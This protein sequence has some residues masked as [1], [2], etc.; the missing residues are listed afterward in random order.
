MEA[1]LGPL[2]WKES[3]SKDRTITKFLGGADPTDRGD[4]PRQHDWLVDQLY[5]MHS[6]FSPILA[7]LQPA[8]LEEIE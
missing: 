1:K 8:K 5:T 7:T 6:F 4:W 2:F 3:A